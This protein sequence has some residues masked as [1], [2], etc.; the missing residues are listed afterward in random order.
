MN[1][2]Y[3]LPKIDLQLF[4]GGGAV[5]DGGASSESAQTEN[6]ESSKQGETLARSGI[7]RRNNKTGDYVMYG[8]QDSDP[9]KSQPEL[10]SKPEPLPA[11]AGQE[12]SGVEVT[13]NTLEEKRKAFRDLV[14]GEY[15]DI[16]TQETQ[17]II[18]RRFRETKQMERQLSSHQP[19]LDLLMQRYQISDGDL[20]KL[21]EAIENDDAY[22]S[23]AAEEA[24]MSV[25]QYK[26]FQKLQRE[27]EAL[28]NAQRQQQNRQAMQ[29]QIQRWYMEGDQ[30]RTL[31]PEF[32]LGAESKNPQ[33]LAMLRAGI[34]VQHA[35]EVIH[36]DEIKT[37]IAKN[38]AKQT[39]KSVVDGIRAKGS[40]PSE[41][42]TSAQS[43][44]T[45]KEDPSKWTKKDRAEVARRVLMGESIRL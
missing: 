22:W 7:T 27:N 45:T 42:G 20:S 15:K 39:E 34:P 5:G 14:N 44:F 37:G 1:E 43:G 41:N 33:F 3:L 11:D 25:E 29:Q 23:E 21:T 36:M 16:Y 28:R 32:D 9:E 26:T 6:N 13:S 2:T 38:A 4:D 35:Y 19:I 40:R 17:R 8:K 18:D 10:E 30:V 24:G 12:K 31:Y